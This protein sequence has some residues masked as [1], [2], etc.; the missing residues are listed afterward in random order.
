MTA[1]RR[2]RRRVGTVASVW[3]VAAGVVLWAPAT[4]AADNCSVFT[5]CFN[6]ANSASEAA[7]GLLLLAGLSLVLDFLP[8]VG[9]AK[10]G[11]EAVT[12]RDLLTGEELADWERSLGLVPFLPVGLLRG[13]GRVDDLA[14]LVRRG[15]D[16]VRPVAPP[17]R[18]ADALPGRRLVDEYRDAATAPARRR[19]IAEQLGE[20]GGQRALR[21]ATG[22]PDL[23]SFRPT[24]DADVAGFAD[25]LDT[26]EAWP[27]AVTFGG[28]RATNIVYWDGQTLH[29]IEAKGGSSAY[30]QRIS[31]SVAPRATISQTNPDYPLDVARDMMNSSLR[32]G[33][34]EIGRAI[35]SAYSDGRVRYVGVR[36]GGRD[37][38]LAGQ[39]TTVV[40]H[41]FRQPD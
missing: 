36:T 24:S 14:G 20:E 35:D 28:S 32:D 25:L 5:D 3:L 1:P 15:D 18:L 31:G 21:E 23:M 41:V 13:A 37:A 12:G 26:G 4:A 10:S 19:Q 38:L 22:R 40:E 2:G 7:F 27:G 39:P 29:I 16:V 11:I 34:N 8:V 9:T 30:G 6:Q 33:R 17:T